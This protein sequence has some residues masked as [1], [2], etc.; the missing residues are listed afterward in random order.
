MGQS[1]EY[2]MV[3]IKKEGMEAAEYPEFYWISSA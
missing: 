2:A 1:H 3:E